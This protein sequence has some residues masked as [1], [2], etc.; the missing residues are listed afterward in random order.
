MPGRSTPAEPKGIE[1]VDTLLVAAAAQRQQQLREE[2]RRHR[3]ATELAGPRRS[4]PLGALVRTAVV[5]TWQDA[6]R[7]VAA[8]GTSVREIAAMPPTAQGQP[9]LSEYPLGPRAT[10]QPATEICTS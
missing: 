10:D 6:R 2:A 8:A 3:L 9:Q 4:V 7:L 5:R 1:M